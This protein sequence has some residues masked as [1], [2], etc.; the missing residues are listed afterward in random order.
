MKHEVR[1]V[2]WRT[3]VE[4]HT[5]MFRYVGVGIHN[6][7]QRKWK[8]IVKVLV[9]PSPGLLRTPTKMPA[10]NPFERDGNERVAPLV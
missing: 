1:W 5:P 10:F 8:E 9:N 6:V 3:V 2:L 4:G 7:M